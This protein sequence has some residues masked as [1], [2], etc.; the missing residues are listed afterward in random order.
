M[1]WCPDFF[2]QEMLVTDR[3]R[4]GEKEKRVRYKRGMFH[5]PAHPTF[6][7]QDDD[8]WRKGKKARW[9]AAG[10]NVRRT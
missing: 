4:L 1:F 8:A 2:F 6:L 9:A 3:C 7:S 5:I 10:N